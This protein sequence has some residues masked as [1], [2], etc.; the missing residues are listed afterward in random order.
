MQESAE[1]WFRKD[2]DR[3]FKAE[4][5]VPVTVKPTRYPGT[6]DRMIRMVLAGVRVSEN[7]GE[8]GG[9]SR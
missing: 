1:P 7:G 5:T 4:I 8:G 2:T 6:Q 3:S 9:K